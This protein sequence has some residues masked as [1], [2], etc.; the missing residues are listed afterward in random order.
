MDFNPLQGVTFVE[1]KN[2]FVGIIDVAGKHHRCYIPNTGR[3]SELLF[4]GNRVYVDYA[5][6]EHRKTAYTLR[7]TEKG[8]KLISIDSHIPN[9]L[10]IEAI[11]K[12]LLPFAPESTIERE[13]T[14]LNSRFDLFLPETKHLIE[15]KGVTL[16]RDGIAAFPDAPT[17]R[18]TKHLR[19]LV[20]ARALGYK[21]SVVFLV[22]FDYASVFRPNASMDP[23]FANALRDAE[24]GGVTIHAVGCTVTLEAIE[25]TYTIPINLEVS[26]DE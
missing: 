24:T 4:P 17:L 6:K 20:E 25:P 14:V 23:E 10:V 13:V 1:K 5:E 11:R 12:G 16:E 26:S 15:V 9:A 19:E 18:G 22:Q 8:D 3:L 7:L 21:C 2:R